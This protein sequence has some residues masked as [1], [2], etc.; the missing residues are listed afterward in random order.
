MC[1]GKAKNRPFP[2]R[3]FAKRFL[4]VFSYFRQVTMRPVSEGLSDSEVGSEG[5]ERSNGKNEKQVFL[6]W[7]FP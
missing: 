7:A 4:L 5:H 3:I 1:E 6:F 2:G